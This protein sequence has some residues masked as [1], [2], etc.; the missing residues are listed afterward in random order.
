MFFIWLKTSVYSSYLK[1]VAKLQ[2]P[3]LSRT[4]IRIPGAFKPGKQFFEIQG[5]S[6]ISRTL[7]TLAQDPKLKP[8]SQLFHISQAFYWNTR[9]PVIWWNFSSRARRIISEMSRL[10]SFHSMTVTRLKM[11]VQLFHVSEH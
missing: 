2:F 4:C 5:L 8:N 9:S 11:Y 3:G 10:I 6:R 1:D 7:R